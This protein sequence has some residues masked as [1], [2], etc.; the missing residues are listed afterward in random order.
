MLPYFLDGK[1]FIFEVTHNLQTL[2]KC[3]NI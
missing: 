2:K 1:T 3:R